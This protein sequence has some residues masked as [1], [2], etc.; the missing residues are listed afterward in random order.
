MPIDYLERRKSAEQGLSGLVQGRD[1]EDELSR[2][3]K[4]IQG[5]RQNFLERAGNLIRSKGGSGIDV[6]RIGE[7]DDRT[8][9]IL[10]RKRRELQL[11]KLQSVFNNAYNLA[12]QAG[13]DEQSAVD[14]ARQTTAQ[15]ESQEF[16]AGEA[17]KGRGFKRKLDTL[18]TQYGIDQMGLLDEFTDSA[19][20]GPTLLAAILGTGTN[21]GIN[22][23]FS[24]K[25]GGGGGGGGASGG[26]GASSYRPF[27]SN[28]VG[29]GDSLMSKSGFVPRY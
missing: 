29:G 21:V 12:V 3:Q 1:V 16:G 9:A 15:K 28:I 10:A 2:I 7:L 23:Y 26:A 4:N 24:N 25:R 27:S 20:L 19:D 14:Y 11:G 13:M 6:G 22:R 18:A 5:S 8:K 17:E